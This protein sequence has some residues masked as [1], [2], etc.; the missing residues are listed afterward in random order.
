MNA[1]EAVAP[2]VTSPLGWAKICDQHPSEW[3]CLVEVEHQTDGQIRSAKVVGHHPSLKSALQQV[4]SWSPDRVVVYAHTGGRK[5]RFPRIEMT[6]EI[7]NLVRA[8]R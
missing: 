8:R 1:A 2:S 6:D 4:E 5:L 7:R 3:V